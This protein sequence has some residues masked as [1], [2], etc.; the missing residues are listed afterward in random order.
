MKFS[1]PCDIVSFVQFFEEHLKVILSMDKRK[2]APFRKVTGNIYF[3]LGLMAFAV[4]LLI[5]YWSK[6]E[7][8]IVMFGNALAP[9]VVGGIIAYAVNILLTFIEKKYNRIFHSERA[10]RIRRPICIVLSYL[11][12]ILI[13]GIVIGILIPQLTSCISLLISQSGAAV[14]QV[15]H[16]LQSVPSLAK[17]GD[18]LEQSM[19]GIHLN[20]EL[21]QKA[22]HIL[23]SG[24]TGWISNVTM[25]LHKVTGTAASVFIGLFFSFYL[26]SGKEK[27]ARQG[28]KV[29]RIY[30]PS[31]EEKLFEILNVFNHSFR[32]FIVGQVK[33]ACVLG[34]MCGVA[35]L[36]FRMPYAGM[37]GVIIAVTALVPIV[38]AIIGASVG[39]I[40]ILSVSVTKAVI[41]VILFLVVQQID[42]NVTYPR[43]VG[44]SIGLPGIWVLAA[45]TIGG[46]AFGVLGMLFFIPLFSA[47]YKLIQTDMRRREEKSI[48]TQSEVE[49]V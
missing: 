21:V 47:I 36:L 14:N 48:E 29:I 28:R 12:L 4:Y 49:N 2:K 27:L 1:A 7:N 45:V 32:S 10:M 18:M 22:L 25:V 30:C 16:L 24:N 15:V 39:F 5:Y 17:Y 42:N 46:S 37:I 38:G 11:L 35:M 6:V 43:I 33:D 44:G 26:L 9:L 40:L 13:I 8:V 3:H 41:F 20:G 23:Q 19:N 31:V 34:L